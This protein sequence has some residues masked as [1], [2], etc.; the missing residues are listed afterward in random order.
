MCHVKSAEA[1]SHKGGGTFLNRCASSTRDK[2]LEDW[3]SSSVSEQQHSCAGH[4]EPYGVRLAW[5]P[6][7]SDEE[8]VVLLPNTDSAVARLIAERIREAVEAHRITVQRD[9]IE[10][11]TT[12]VC[13]GIAAV[14][15]QE[16]DLALLLMRADRALYAAKR[17]GRNGVRME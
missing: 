9:R 16:L 12:P 6:A 5:Q 10:H 14:Q 3:P 17:V 4:V 2:T 11:L 15:S 7:Q 13:T 1:L 8:F